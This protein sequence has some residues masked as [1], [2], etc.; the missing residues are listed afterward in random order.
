MDF[1]G[2]MAS[3][4]A[5]YLKQ[6]AYLEDKKE[7]A[8]TQ[9]DAESAKTLKFVLSVRCFNDGRR[10]KIS[11]TSVRST[12]SKDTLNIRSMPPILDR[13]ERDC[14]RKQLEDMRTPTRVQ[15]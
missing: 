15:I 6:F 12:E 14:P 8:I 13:M 3:K 2:Q 10:R 5:R 1:K 9:S 7:K 4:P 11:M